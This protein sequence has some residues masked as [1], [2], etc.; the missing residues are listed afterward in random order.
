MKKIKKRSLC[1]ISSTLDVIGDKWSLLIIRD[2]LFFKKNTYGDFLNS[3]EKIAT[4]ILADRLSLL[5]K[6]GIITKHMYPDNKAKY[7]YRLTQKGK[8][9][10]PVL[11]EMLLW[12]NKY[13]EVSERNHIIARSIRNDKEFFIKEIISGLDTAE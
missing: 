3:N 12:S 4:N 9:L 11:L 1:G 13:L 7:L 10:L 2:M 8:D 5:E 6:E